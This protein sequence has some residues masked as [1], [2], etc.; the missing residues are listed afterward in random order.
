MN[1]REFYYKKRSLGTKNLN[2]SGWNLGIEVQNFSMLLLSLEKGEIRWNI[3]KMIQGHYYN[4]VNYQ[5]KNLL[6][7]RENPLEN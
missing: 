4:L 1:M 3:L 2:A 7:N 5:W 6:V